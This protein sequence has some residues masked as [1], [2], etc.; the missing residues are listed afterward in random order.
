[1]N[2]T[3]TLTWKDN[4]T[5]IRVRVVVVVVVVVVNWVLEEEQTCKSTMK[6][7]AVSR[8]TNIKRNYY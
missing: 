5:T 1:M 6:I 3:L 8:I 7:A 4:T 2:T